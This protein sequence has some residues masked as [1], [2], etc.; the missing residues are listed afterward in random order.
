M[1]LNPISKLRVLR[2]GEVQHCLFQPSAIVRQII[3]GQ[4]GERAKAA[5]ATRCQG[6]DQQTGCS[7]WSIWLLEICDNGRVLHLQC[8]RGRVEVIAL[9]S[10]GQ[11]HDMDVF[12]GH[13]LD[14]GTGIL[15]RDKDFFDRAYDPS[16]A[17]CAISHQT[18]IEPILGI[19][20]VGHLRAA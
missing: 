17:V 1:P 2:P 19:K 6:C 18:A 9:F 16:L 4:G 15:W 5:C 8:P 13:G 10:N 3:A 20:L 11:R 7:G 12:V 14:Q